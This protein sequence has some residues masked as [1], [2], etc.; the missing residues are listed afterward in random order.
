MKRFT[1]REEYDAYVIVDNE[2]GN[3]YPIEYKRNSN[4]IHALCEL[5]N[6]LNEMRR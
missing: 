6:E 1:V 3:E 4:T 2:Y 5:L